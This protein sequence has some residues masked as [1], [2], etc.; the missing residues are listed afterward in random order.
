MIKKFFKSELGKGSLILFITMNLFNFFNFLFHF[1][2]G[3]LLGPSD[4][5]ILAALMSLIYIYNVPVEAIQNIISRYT[6][7]FNLKKEEGKTK[8]LVNKSLKKGL[9]LRTIYRLYNCNLK[10]VNK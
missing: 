10:G 8:F 9:F 1:S 2:M 5:G 7:T 4:Y 3:R 6:S